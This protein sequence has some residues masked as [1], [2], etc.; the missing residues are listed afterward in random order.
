MQI[1]VEP[2]HDSNQGCSTEP[3]RNVESVH[4]RKILAPRRAEGTPR[5][6]GA[7]A[8]IRSRTCTAAQH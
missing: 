7:Y 5:S 6:P 1:A 2:E 8:N 4:A 3:K